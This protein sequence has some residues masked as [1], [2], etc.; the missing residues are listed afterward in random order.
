[1]CIR[2]RANNWQRTHRLLVHSSMSIGRRIPINSC[3][4][5]VENRNSHRNFSMGIPRNNGPR[6][7]TSGG[8]GVIQ[9]RGYAGRTIMRKANQG[10][11]FGLEAHY[12]PSGRNTYLT[13]VHNGY[14]GSVSPPV[15]ISNIRTSV[16]INMV[17]LR[18]LPTTV[19][20][21]PILRIVQVVP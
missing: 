13:S 12:F 1:M 14:V 16:N 3:H 2:D 18:L 9:N 15:G 19:L 21:D 11:Q 17:V 10:V 8:D 6:F 20:V 4:P 7:C 5:S